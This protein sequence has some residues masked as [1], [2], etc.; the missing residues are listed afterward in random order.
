MSASDALGVAG[1]V[2]AIIGIAVAAYYGRRAVNPPKR[3]MQ[4]SYEST[5]L[6]SGYD[7]SFRDAIEVQVFGR[8]VRNP[9]VG[10]LIIEN[11]GRHDIDSNSFDQGRP[12]Q[13]TV[14]RATK[15]GTFLKLEG[16]PPGLRTDGN[17][18]LLGPELFPS[19]SKW[20]ISFV[21]DGRPQ[22]SLTA[23]PLIDV[24]L[25]SK[26]SNSGQAFASLEI[27]AAIASGGIAVIAAILAA[28]IQL[29]HLFR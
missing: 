5:P 7:D 6:I 29:I 14:Q 21:T 17:S 15:V 11:V 1:V 28:I 27:R 8:K 2:V 25:R 10:K 19:R 18:I 26:V 12:V 23:A 22:I 3:L 9:Y 20:T 13:F 4:W 24:K 16:N